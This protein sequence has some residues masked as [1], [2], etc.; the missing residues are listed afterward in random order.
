LTPARR[1][2]ARAATMNAAYL[3]HPERFGPPIPQLP[4][5][6]VWINK[7]IQLEVEHETKLIAL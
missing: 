3:A 2:A 7:P 5:T 6:K 1:I 4:P